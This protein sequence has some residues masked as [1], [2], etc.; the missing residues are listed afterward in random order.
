MNIKEQHQ[1]PCKISGFHS[2]FD[3]DS[4]LLICVPRLVFADIL[5]SIA[6]GVQEG[7]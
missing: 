6:P 5:T 2:S 7:I 1:F 4:S 3:E